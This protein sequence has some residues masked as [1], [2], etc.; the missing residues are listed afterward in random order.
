MLYERIYA[1]YLQLDNQ[2]NSLKEE[3][4]NLPP[5]KLICC[6]Q[7]KYCKWYQSNGHTRQ[8]IP[9]ENLALAEALARKKYL[10]LL[11]IDLEKEKCAL[12][13]YLRHHASPKA[14]NLLVQSSEYRQLLAPYFSP[15][16][17]E[18][19]T[20]M[21]E[22]YECNPSHPEGLLYK[23]ISGNTVRSKSEMMIDMCLSI[24]KIPFRYESPLQLGDTTLY[25][26]FTIRH[27]ATGKYCYWEHF[28]LIDKPSYI[29][30]CI[31]KLRL[32]TSH[33]LIP[34][35]HLITTY[36]TKDDPLTTELIEMLTTHY[37]L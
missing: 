16:S 9:K 4:K 11:L 23:S 24:H 12:S 26:D 15:L 1:E 22:P 27:P 36:E 10:S 17:K 33:G 7:Q 8:Y 21:Q 13:F 28:G 32:Y 5:G 37:F 18:L 29:D 20:W 35:I 3:L 19:S 14:E 25:P 31:A 6:N 2:I 34:G 30:N